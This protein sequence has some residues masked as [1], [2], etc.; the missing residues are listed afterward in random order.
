MPESIPDT[1]STRKN[2]GFRLLRWGIGIPLTLLFIIYGGSYF[3]DEPLR[4]YFE[5]KINSNLKGYTVRLPG[6][7]FQVLG[8]TL[9]LRGLTLFQQAHPDPPIINFPVIKTSVHWREILSGKL[10]AEVQL[11]QPRININLQQ[12]NSEAASKVPLKERGWQQA[13]EDIY[14]LKINTVT[15]NDATVTYIDQ[16]PKRPLVLNR[17]NFHAANIRNIRQAE[18]PYPSP[19]HL[20]TAIFG[21]GHG[22][23]DGDANFLAEPYPGLKARFKLEK[24]PIDYFNSIVARSNL[25][26]Q[27]GVLGTSGTVVYA[28]QVK[29]AH[30]ENL[31]IQ[32]MKLD[33]THSKRTAVAEKKR[34]VVVSKTAKKL[35]NKPAVLIRADRLDLIDC[36]IG[37]I[38]RGVR[39]PY[40]VFFSETDLHLSNFSNQFSQGP[41]EV[42][43]KAKFMGSG[44]TTASATLRPENKGP[45]FDLH[46]KTENTRLASLNDV[47]RSYG[48]FD[49][50]AGLFSLVSEIHIKSGRITG[51]IK[52]FFKD[53]NVYDRKTDKGQGALHSMYEMAVGGAAQLLKNSSNKEVATKVDISG[54]VDNPDTD[55]WQIVGALFRNAFIK[56]ILPNFEKST[57]GAVKRKQ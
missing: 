2:R 25:T 21:T 29:I 38:N 12:L 23:V 56:A 53:L 14:P 40:R 37:M 24:T 5:R 1:S 30:L 7:H 32:G 16:D 13:L 17:L 44:I 39:T 49:V 10:V 26:I 18:N 3:F 36:T 47:L 48:N 31:T 20:D 11:D 9:T 52:P 43:L 15:V 28:P 50:S 33:Y 45:D 22:V 46:I 19:F 27:G 4:S 41:A 57:G 51:Y 34:A 55:T 8:L 54:R 42:H 35:S 6:A